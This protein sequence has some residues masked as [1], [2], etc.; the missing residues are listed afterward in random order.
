M[1]GIKDRVS[2][3]KM[4]INKNGCYYV[5]YKELY[6][7]F[8]EQNPSAKIG[9]E[10]FCALRPKWCVNAGASGTHAVCVCTI[11]QNVVLLIHAAHLEESYK[12]LLSL[13]VCCVDNR[14]CMLQRCTRC[15]GL[16]TVLQLL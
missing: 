7:H 8:K 13:A 2:V 10:K 12:D 1:L 14:D 3:K 4:F 11:H 9:L 16:G 6:A 5:L 15:P